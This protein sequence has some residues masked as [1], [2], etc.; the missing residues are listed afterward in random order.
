MSS[1]RNVFKTQLP[2]VPLSLHVHRVLLCFTNTS[3]ASRATPSM[4][5]LHSHVNPDGVDGDWSDLCVRPPDFFILSFH[6]IHS[7]PQE[8]T[9]QLHENL[10]VKQSY[11]HLI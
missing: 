5:S 11:I 10:N 1:F 9:R 3:S 7:Q 2:S 6:N 4:A 8:Q